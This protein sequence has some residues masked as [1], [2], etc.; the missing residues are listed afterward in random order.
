MINKKLKRTAIILSIAAFSIAGIISCG[1][2]DI[3]GSGGRGRGNNYTQKSDSNDNNNISIDKYNGYQ[4]IDTKYDYLLKIE[5]ARGRVYVGSD[6]SGGV[7]QSSKAN[8]DN[9]YYDLKVHTFYGN[10]KLFTECYYLD[11]KDNKLKRVDFY[12]AENGYYI[13]LVFD[14]GGLHQ[15]RIDVSTGKINEDLYYKVVK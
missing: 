11:K 4:Y 9:L 13:E 14:D 6:T 7:S 8:K 10:Y 5:V 2:I 1:G 3:T 12:P 15:R